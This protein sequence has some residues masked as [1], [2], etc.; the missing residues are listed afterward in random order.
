MKRVLLPS[1]NLQWQ[2]NSNVAAAA[3]AFFRSFHLKFNKEVYRF[4]NNTQSYDDN[5]ILMFLLRWG[6]RTDAKL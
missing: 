3:A 4:R 1:Y 2:Q 5:D 6:G